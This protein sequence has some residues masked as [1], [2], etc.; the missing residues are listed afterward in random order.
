MQSIGS[1]AGLLAGVGYLLILGLV[2]D[3]YGRAIV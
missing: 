1:I 3:W 2:W